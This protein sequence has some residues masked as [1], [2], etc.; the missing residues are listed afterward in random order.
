MNS[1]RRPELYNM[2]YV[3]ENSERRGQKNMEHHLNHGQLCEKQKVTV[4]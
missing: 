2:I 4:L 1:P 3:L